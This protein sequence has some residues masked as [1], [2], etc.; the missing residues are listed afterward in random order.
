MLTAMTDIE[1]A[2][3]PALKEFVFDIDNFESCFPKSAVDAG[4]RDLS[5]GTRD[6]WVETSPYMASLREFFA[7]L[8]AGGYGSIR[9]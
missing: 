1:L 6:E 3:R 2:D 4:A 7:E 8:R 5:L 9:F